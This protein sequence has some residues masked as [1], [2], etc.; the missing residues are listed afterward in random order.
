MTGPPR[1]EAGGS[2]GF[3]WTGGG[4]YCHLTEM[5]GD[6]WEAPEPE[7]AGWVQALSRQEGAVP[8]CHT[9]PPHRMGE[10]Q[11]AHPPSSPAGLR[12]DGCWDREKWVVNLYPITT[13]IG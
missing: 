1:K 3:G 5:T 9:P 12:S 10:R 8:S 6:S 4:G 2:P 13:L 7:G 11:E